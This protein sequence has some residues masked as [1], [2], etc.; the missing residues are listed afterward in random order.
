M[1]RVLKNKKVSI[2][3]KNY[4]EIKDSKKYYPNYKK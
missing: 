2:S 4:L 3:I 1:L